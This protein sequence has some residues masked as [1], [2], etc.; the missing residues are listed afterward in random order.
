MKN[1][2]GLMNLENLSIIE[3]G[4]LRK[5]HEIMV[6]ALSTCIFCKKALAFLDANNFAYK[7]LFIDRIPF[8]SKSAIKK[9]LGERFK[10]NII[11]PFM[12]IDARKHLIGFIESEWKMALGA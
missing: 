2:R 5:D 11:F 1:W 10:E 3:K 6:Y 7:Y 9:E 8:E 4:G 12:V